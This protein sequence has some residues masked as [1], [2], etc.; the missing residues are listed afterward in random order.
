[1]GLSARRMSDDE[2][3]AKLEEAERAVLERVESGGS[4]KSSVRRSMREK[5]GS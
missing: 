2:V 4:G 1:M 5:I 3:E